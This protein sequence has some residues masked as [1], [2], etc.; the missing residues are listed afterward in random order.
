IGANQT[1]SMTY[2]YV[3]GATQPDGVVNQTVQ[4]FWSNASTFSSEVQTT[5]LSTTCSFTVS[6]VANWASVHGVKAHEEGGRVVLEWETAAEIGTAGFRVLRRD[7]R[8]GELRAVSGRLLPASGQAAGGVY[9]FVDETAPTSGRLTYKIVEQE[10]RGSE[11]EHG[12]FT[13]AVQ[14]GPAVLTRR[15]MAAGFQAEPHRPAEKFVAALRAAAREPVPLAASGPTAA[16]RLKLLTGAAG[17]YT[18]RAADLAAAFGGSPASAAAQIAQ[19]RYRLSNRG[20]DVAWRPA[21][22]G[23]GLVFYAGPVDPSLSLYN[24][25]NVYWL[26]GGSGVS[27]AAATGGAAAAPAPQG[28]SFQD[29]QHVKQSVF[30]SPFATSDPASDYWF[31]RAFLSGDPQIGHGSFAVTLAGAPAPGAAAAL[32]VNLMGFSSSHRVTVAVN[33]SAAGEVDWTA[34]GTGFGSRHSATL[35]LAPGQLVAGANRIDLVGLDGIF[36]LDSF[37]VSYRRLYVASGDQLALRGDANAVVTATGFSRSDIAVYD[38]SNPQLP[39]SVP[40]LVDSDPAGG[41]RV[42][43]VPGSPASP[44][45]AASGAA[46]TA[47]AA[48]ART[49]AGLAGARNGASD[50]IITAA[51]L[52]TA[53]QALASYRSGRGVAS[54][55]VTVDDIMDDFAFGLL[56]PAAIHE[57]LAFAAASWQPS[58]RYVTLAGKGTYDYRNLLGFGDDLVPP[59]MVASYEGLVPSDGAFADLNGDGIPD[60]AIGRIPALNAAELTAYVNK[61][62]AYEGGA[63]GI[64][65]QRVLMVADAPDAAGNYAAGSDDL[66]SRL[67]AGVQVDKDYLPDGADAQQLAAARSQLMGGFSNGRAL[68]NYVGHGGLDRLATDGLLTV[69]DVG[70]L[71][72]GARSPILTALTCN[73]AHFAYPGFRFL[74][75]D[76]VLQPGGGAIAIYAPSGLSYNGP[77]VQLGEQLL[78]SLLGAQGSALG[79]AILQGVGAYA[80]SGD[81]TLLP[82]YNLLGDPVLTVK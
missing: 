37:D 67:P 3:V 20:V 14:Q 60:L 26:D 78:P 64:W 46:I 55:V 43:F 22:D 53:A 49:D 1:G 82:A 57:F 65:S 58:P 66:A 19:H 77:A 62:Q 48:T 28:Q 24:L 23:Q 36:F 18:V 51:S 41:Y 72:G 13:V 73:I 71:T 21:A 39:K 81:R 5:A 9:R 63:T 2:Q 8:S 30:A 74:G 33:G 75:E 10:L 80:K 38:L 16:T 42:T 17:L 70:Q 34:D 54:Q 61:V 69:D 56:D 76:L 7:E 32:T 29:S 27:I 59:M 31:W 79:D 15:A 68:V 50:L 4:S 12:P 11:R 25:K 45:L 35:S 40:A 47:A 52:R 6:S 44:S